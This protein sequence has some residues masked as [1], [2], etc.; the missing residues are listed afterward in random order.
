[1][2]RL[3]L[4]WCEMEARDIDQSKVMLV[5]EKQ[6]RMV[7]DDPDGSPADKARLRE[8]V[9]A[10]SYRSVQQQEVEDMERQYK[11][12]LGSAVV[13]KVKDEIRPGLVRLVDRQRLAR[14]CVGHFF[15][16]IEKGKVTTKKFFC[17]LSPNRKTLH[18]SDPKDAYLDASSAVRPTI[19]QLPPATTGEGG[20]TIA[21]DEIKMFEYGS[22]VQALKTL[23]T[24]PSEEN[25]RQLAFAIN[26]DQEDWVVFVATDR[27]TAVIW[28]DGL[29]QLSQKPMRVK[30]TES[31]RTELLELQM[32]LLLMNCHG[33]ELPSSVPL[34]PPPPTSFDFHFQDNSVDSSA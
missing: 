18:W 4:T 30:E 24:K 1:M 17:V 26:V 8:T 34:V 3:H 27:E 28:I 20:G 32:N 14:M 25:Y 21:V 22:E 12:H 7:L 15:H 31:A 13:S 6:L 29:G 19:A 16:T 23:K 11:T 10:Y 5:V 2:E 9:L 33:I